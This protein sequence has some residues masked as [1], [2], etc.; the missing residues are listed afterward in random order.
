MQNVGQ[1][2]H[3]SSIWLQALAIAVDDL[4]V[5]SSGSQWL[6]VCHGLRKWC[7]EVAL[8]MERADL[9]GLAGDISPKATTNSDGQVIRLK[10]RR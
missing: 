4:T 10:I 6:T 5:K 8:M 3:W 1:K 7:A 2:S 9:S